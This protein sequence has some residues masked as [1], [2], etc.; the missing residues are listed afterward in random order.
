MSSMTQARLS[1]AAKYLEQEAMERL[2]PFFLLRPKIYPDGE[3]WCALYGENLQDG[4][5]GFGDT[6]EKA[7]IQFDIEWL[8]QKAGAQTEE[9][10]ADT[11]KRGGCT[12]KIIK[13]TIDEEEALEA[14]KPEI[15]IAVWRGN[16][17]IKRIGYM[18]RTTRFNV[19]CLHIGE[20]GYLQPEVFA[21]AKSAVERYNNID[22][23]LHASF[24]QKQVMDF[25]FNICRE[26]GY[27][28]KAH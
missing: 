9:K 27:Q 25:R 23:C 10:P 12:T 17:V 26:C 22:A 21:T 3:S 14:I 20:G 11:I 1:A 7:S 13:K 28:W 15:D 18:P 5:C 4:V 2:R 19:H 16:A 24:E 6:P 8:N